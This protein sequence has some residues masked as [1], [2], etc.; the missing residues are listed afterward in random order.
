MVLFIIVLREV[1]DQYIYIYVRVQHKP[2]LR[3]L[4]PN[5]TVVLKSTCAAGAGFN[6]AP[7]VINEQR[8]VG[9]RCGPFDTALRLLEGPGGIDV[10][11][12]IMGETFCMFFFLA[13]VTFPSC[14]RRRANYLR[15][16]CHFFQWTSSQDI[17]HG[18]HPTLRV[19]LSYSCLCVVSLTGAWKNI[20]CFVLFLWM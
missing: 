8:V 6:A 1:L 3:P 16:L 10:E 7:V 15:S 5:R 9:S 12:Y 13:F 4:K 11:R 2:F 14:S 17:F 20:L 19:C 18:S